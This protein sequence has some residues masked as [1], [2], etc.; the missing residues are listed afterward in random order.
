M[1]KVNIF[2]SKEFVFSIRERH[3]LN[4]ASSHASNLDFIFPNKP[5]YFYLFY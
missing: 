4:N 3:N 5:E 2:E 1:E